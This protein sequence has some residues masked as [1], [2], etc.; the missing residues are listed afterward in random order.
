MKPEKHSH[1]AFLQA[2]TGVLAELSIWETNVCTKSLP[3]LR[4]YQLDVT[5]RKQ[6]EEA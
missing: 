1:R 2:V 3:D 6:I 5:S 4:D